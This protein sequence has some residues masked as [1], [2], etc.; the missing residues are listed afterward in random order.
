MI[1]S[2]R[3]DVEDDLHIEIIAEASG[4]QVACRKVTELGKECDLLML[5]DKIACS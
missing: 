5:A 2:I 3:D 1:D 4:S